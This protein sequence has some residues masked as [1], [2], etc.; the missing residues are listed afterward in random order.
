MQ[1]QRILFKPFVY[2]QVSGESFLAGFFLAQ[3]AAS[4]PHCIPAVRSSYL[5]QL[6]PSTRS[7]RSK[8]LPLHK[9]VSS[10]EYPLGF[11]CHAPEG[12]QE[13]SSEF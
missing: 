13:R 4:Y 10:Q 7:A 2:R 3:K 11:S 12:R 9:E 5:Q 6:A 1:T 8:L